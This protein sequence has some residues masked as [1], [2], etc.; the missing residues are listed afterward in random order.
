MGR[1]RL[2]K[3]PSSEAR[4]FF[5]VV[6]LF[7]YLHQ[8]SWMIPQTIVRQLNHALR[9]AQRSSLVADNPT[10]CFIT[11]FRSKFLASKKAHY[12]YDLSVEQN[13]GF[14]TW[15][16]VPDES[17]NKWFEDGCQVLE[18][19]TRGPL[20]LIGA[21]MGLWLS[22]LIATRSQQSLRTRVRG[23]LGIGG[24]VDF[25][26]R[27]LQRE[28]PE[29]H[30]SNR[31]Y[32]WHRPSAYAEDGYYAIPIHTLLD[33][34]PVLILDDPTSLDTLNC[35]VHLIHG[36]QDHDVDINHAW[37]LYQK[38]SSKT[39]RNRK[40]TLQVVPDGDHRLSRPQDLELVKSWLLAE[41]ARQHWQNPGRLPAA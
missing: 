13:C 41:A 38:L 15:D 7:V 40:L 3:E 1:R 10:L 37:S 28:V 32:V 25:T 17:V 33:S 2:K 12:I 18:T 19:C 24:G 39:Q 27:W 35:D 20:Y 30:R 26:E 36:Q 29:E 16:H 31:D 22:L 4:A 8:N 14:I 23:I 11:G 21:S 5:Q 34:R 6:H 9:Y